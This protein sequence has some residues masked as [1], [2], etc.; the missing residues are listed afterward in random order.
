VPLVEDVIQ[1]I[2]LAGMACEY[3]PDSDI[4]GGWGCFAGNQQGTP[5]RWLQLS[6]DSDESGPIR[7][8]LL[9]VFDDSRPPPDEMNRH[10]TAI[11]QEHAIVPFLP[12]HVRPSDEELL[13]MVEKNWPVELGDGW[14]LGFDRS[15]NQRTLRI[16]FDEGSDVYADESGG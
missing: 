15:S 3:S 11:F 6:I 13:A 1:R 16:V 7:G 10:A 14:L 2:E 8:V 12:E 9:F 4:P 5:A